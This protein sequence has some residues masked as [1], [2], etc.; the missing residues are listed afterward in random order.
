VSHWNTTATLV[1]IGSLIALGCLLPGWIQGHTGNAAQ[2]GVFTGILIMFLA[3]ILRRPDRT[4]LET[5]N[6]TK[7]QAL[8]EE[9]AALS[10]QREL[11]ETMRSELEQEL[12]S[13]ARRIDAREVKLDNRLITFQEWLEYPQVNADN[14]ATE[15][16]DVAPDSTAP[17]LSQQDQQV[18]DL[19]EKEASAVYE[20]LKRSF[21][22]QDD[23]RIDPEKVRHDLQDLVTRVAR[24]YRPEADNPLLETSVEQLLRAGSRT[25]LHL[26]IVLERLPLNMKDANFA[27]VYGHLTTAVKAYDVYRSAE[28]W[29]GYAGRALYGARMV[30]GANPVTL[31]L[32]WVLTELG[33]AGVKHAARKF[34]D[35]QAVNILHDLVRV[36]GFE[37]AAVYGGDFRYRD[38]NWVYARE[39]TDLMSRF[40]VSRESLAHCLREIGNLPLRNEYDRVYLYRCLSIHQSPASQLNVQQTLSQNDR[41]E[42][43][44]KL[45]QFF[46]TF[47]HGRTKQRTEEWVDDLEQRLGVRLSIP[48]SVDAATAR[49][50][51]SDRDRTARSL[52]A[53]LTGVKARPFKDMQQRLATS[54]SLSTLEEDAR[55][56]FLDELAVDSLQFFEPPDVDSQ[57]EALDDFFEDLIRFSI[58]TPPLD[59]QADDLILEMA[60]YFGRELKQTRRQID[61]SY[62]ESFTARLSPDAPSGK[63]DAVA[64]RLMTAELCA[65]ESPLFAYAGVTVLPADQLPPVLESSARAWLLATSSRIVVLTENIGRVCEIAS[66]GVKLEKVDGMVIDDCQ[67][68]GIWTFADGTD[69]PLSVTISGL[70]VPRYDSYFQPLISLINTHS[71]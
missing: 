39:L 52:A 67:L 71:A 60:T 14:C 20:K 16:P 15:S 48:E 45:E 26:L 41:Q 2:T 8:D 17:G 50:T 46:R 36:I 27:T 5:D 59:V 24:I 68:S 33:K 55:T 38:P 32:G 44:R 54:K 66:S 25:C 10:E 63:I 4:Q 61:E 35:Y 43:A 53:F 69:C 21:Y 34:V 18:H 11:L 22:R 31:G 30:S 58:R 42:V 37:V 23:G 64:A 47:V 19:L 28:P 3:V 62:V 12:I 13:R 56:T 65:D 29:L 51:G 9:S 40:P 6:R 57:S 70:V 7:Q 49:S 1:S